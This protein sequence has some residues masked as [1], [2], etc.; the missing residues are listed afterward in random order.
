MT[1]KSLILPLL[2]SSFLFAGMSDESW[3]TLKKQFMLS[4][5]LSQDA[6]IRFGMA[7]TYAYTGFIQEGFTEIAA[8]PSIDPTFK[9]KVIDKYLRKIMLYPKNWQYHWYLAFAYYVN[10]RKDDAIIEFQ[11]VIN[12]TTDSSVKG[13]AFGYIAYIYG[14]R[15][16]WPKAMIAINNAIKL[17]PDGGALYFAKGLALK[18][19]GD[20]VGA[21]GALV[22]AGTLQAK[23]MMGKRSI[24]RLKNDQ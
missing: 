8:I 4:K 23:Q 17:E 13:W 19:T 16:D 22:M 14:E 2:I 21:A 5:T 15:K 1:L 10:E 3:A 20:T 6:N 12:L 24:S 7:M 11:K 9:S 18:E